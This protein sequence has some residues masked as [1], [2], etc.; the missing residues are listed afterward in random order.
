MVHLFAAIVLGYI[1]GK[2]IVFSV[3]YITLSTA[4]RILE[5]STT[6]QREISNIMFKW[7]KKNQR[8]EFCVT[9]QCSPLALPPN[10][11]PNP[12]SGEGWL[13]HSFTGNE[14]VLYCLRR[15]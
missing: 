15:W 2:V 1:I 12:P 8:T 4:L 7:F 5:T 11:L 13:L 6:R 9:Q 14:M 10:Y 3:K